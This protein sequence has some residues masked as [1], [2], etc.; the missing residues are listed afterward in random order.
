M[1]KL[2][3]FLADMPP[4]P[5]WP[6]PRPNPPATQGWALAVFWIILVVT[7]IVGVSTDRRNKEK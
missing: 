3:L 4:G 5:A 6:R 2:I 1:N 7:V